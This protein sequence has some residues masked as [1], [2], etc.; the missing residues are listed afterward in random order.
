MAIGICCVGHPCVFNFEKYWVPISWTILFFLIE[1]DPVALKK[2]NNTPFVL[3]H[4]N[5]FCRI[6]NNTALNHM[7]RN[8]RIWYCIVSCGTIWYHIIWYCIQLKLYDIVMYYMTQYCTI[9]MIRIKNYAFISYNIILY[10]MT[11]YCIMIWY[12]IVKYVTL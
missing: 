10:H 4:M 5:R 1:F 7:I 8:G 11:W 9:R 2:K 3:Y 6:W 12:C